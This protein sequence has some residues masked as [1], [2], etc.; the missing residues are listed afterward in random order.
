MTDTETQLP[1]PYSALVRALFSDPRHVV[2]GPAASGC[3]HEVRVAE[4]VAGAQILLSAVTQND[5][6]VSLRF[7]VFGCPHL[8][9]AAEWCCERYEGGPVNKMGDFDVPRL[10]E[11]LG[12]PIEK[13]GRILLLEDAIRSLCSQIDS[14][15]GNQERKG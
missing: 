14:A 11:T 6:L 10:M 8:V 4:S 5:V 3:Q 2:S 1:G 15:S 12:V 7:R 9:S 13:F